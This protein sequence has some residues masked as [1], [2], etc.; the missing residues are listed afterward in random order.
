MTTEPLGPPCE[1]LQTHNALTL[2]WNGIKICEIRGGRRSTH[3]AC[4][5]AGGIPARQL[6]RIVAMNRTLEGFEL[7]TLLQSSARAQAIRVSRPEVLSK[8]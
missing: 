4:C 2:Y 3:L 7:R 1:P 8:S 6:D 5:S